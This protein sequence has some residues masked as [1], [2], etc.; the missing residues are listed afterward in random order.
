MS[1]GI[2]WKLCKKFK[3]D[4][5]NKWY[6]HN[7]ESILENETHKLLWDF[8]IRMDHLISARRPDPERVN[9]KRVPTEQWTLLF[10]LSTGEKWRKA[11]REINTKNLLENEKTIEH[12]LTVIPIVIGALGTVTQGLVQR[13]KDL[14]ISGRVETMQTTA[15]LRST[16]ILRSVLKIWGDL[17]SLKLL[18]ETVS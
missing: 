2:H 3:F 12:K 4:H 6:M 16:K 9:K 8:E 5:P 18:L 14:E 1:K 15:L 11:K 10:R 7:P 13:M 17:L